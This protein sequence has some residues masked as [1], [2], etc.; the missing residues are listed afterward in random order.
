MCFYTI[1]DTRPG[2]FDVISKPIFEAVNIPVILTG[3]VK[4]GTDVMDILDRN[5]CDLV[6]I[7]RSVFKESDWMN[8]ELKGLIK[9]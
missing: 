8:R 4:K 2:Y 3:G 7:G 5:V 9:E 1:K 6:G